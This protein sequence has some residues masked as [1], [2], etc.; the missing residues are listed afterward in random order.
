MG[1]F[2][3]DY[4]SAGVGISKNAPKKTGVKLYFDLLF[5]KFWK[6]LEV[7]LLYSI[8]FLPFILIGT[9]IYL[10]D[11]LTA[12]LIISIV[13]GLVFM[14]TIGP[15]TAGMTKIMRKFILDKHSFIIRD[16]FKAFKEN[17]KYASIIGFIDIIL[18]I[19]IFAGLS[20][21][22]ALAQQSGSKWFY[23]PLV[24]SL[25]VAI[26][27]LMMNFYLFLMMIATDLSFKNLLKNSFALAFVELKANVITCVVIILALAVM[28]LL[29]LFIPPLFYTL[30]LIFPAAFISFTVCFN[31]YPAIQKYVINPYYESIGQINPELVDFDIDDDEE[32]IFEDMGGKE[33]PIEKR[34]KGKGKR[35]S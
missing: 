19:S 15:A 3:Q 25:S 11:N 1:I 21:Y 8:F 32:P 6:I 26:V 14:L 17:F 22:P 30:I 34:K 18:L 27:V 2:S 4:E 31:S 5:R 28:F 12:A 7:N 10:V 9:V 24:I 29:F 16:F 13:L 33:K 20:I 23:V 35:I